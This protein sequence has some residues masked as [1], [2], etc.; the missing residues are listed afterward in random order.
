M[1]G[2]T[3]DEAL[4]WRELMELELGRDWKLINPVR[5]PPDT[6]RS[7]VIELQTQENNNLDLC[8][9]ATALVTADTFFIDQCDWV[10]ANLT[11]TKKPSF[12]TVWELGYAYHARK[13]II[14]IMKPEDE[15]NHPFTRR[16]VDMFTPSL[17]EVIEFFK[18]I[19]P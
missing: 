4:E 9:T 17:K 11:N 16:G 10:V 6:D 1:S 5:P 2:S 14:V 19:K 12:G 15:H 3:W 13:K 7:K 18:R 8:D